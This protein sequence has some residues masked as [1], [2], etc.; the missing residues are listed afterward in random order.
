MLNDAERQRYDRQM[1]IY[2]FGEEGQEKL[3]RARVFI[4]GAG[5]LGSPIAMY[6]AAAGVGRIR[7]VDNDKVDLSN[8]NRQLLHW[9]ANTGQLK[10]DSAGDK[11]RQLNPEIIIETLAGTINEGTAGDLVGDSDCIIDAM[12]NLPT[13]YLLNK[14]AI[15][16]RIPYFHGAVY[17]LDGRALTV[18]P[19]Q[20]ACLYCL[21]HGVLPPKEK[22]PILGA[23]AGV[24]GCVQA[25]EVIKY[26]TGIGELLTG[27]LF[28]YDGLSMKFSEFKINL[29]PACEHCGPVQNEQRQQV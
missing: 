5:G 6:L 29:D 2:G 18:I 4:A 8:L 1:L 26:F 21:Y 12:D 23:T 15:E 3:K 14:T 22:F 20:S 16:R 28:N 11:L 24:I 13:R 7:I 25:S 27:R 10:A 9:T 19:G 17:G